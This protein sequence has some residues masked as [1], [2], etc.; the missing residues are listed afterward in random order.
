MTLLTRGL[1]FGF[2]ERCSDLLRSRP[3]PFRNDSKKN[4]VT[5]NGRHCSHKPDEM[6]TAYSIIKKT[7]QV[8]SALQ[9]FFSINKVLAN[10]MLNA[11][12]HT[13]IFMHSIMH[14]TKLF[15]RY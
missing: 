15:G 1:Y 5:W 11:H 7:G 8:L 12:T 13:I 6:H 2:L 4:A 10:K 9:F 14:K 3:G